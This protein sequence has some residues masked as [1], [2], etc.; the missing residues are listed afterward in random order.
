MDVRKLV[1]FVPVVV[2]ACLAIAVRHEDAP[3][4]PR[5]SAVKSD[6]PP[7]YRN[8]FVPRRCGW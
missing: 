8:S 3:A 7:R 6:P 4:R 1:T 5:L 2:F